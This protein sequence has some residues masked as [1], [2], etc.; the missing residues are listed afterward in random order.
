M[1]MELVALV[2]LIALSAFFSGSETA[3]TSLDGMRTQKLIDAGRF[4]SQALKLWRDR[5]L[6]VLTCILIGN[7]IVN[8]TASVMSDRL[9]SSLLEGTPYADGS[10]PLAIGVMTFIILTFGEI[11]PKT[12][13]KARPDRI[14]GQLMWTL[15]LPYVLFMPLTFFFTH[16]TRLM[17]R[18]MGDDPDKVRP[19]VTEEDIGYMVR[20][21]SEDGN[22]GET[23]QDML[24]SVLELSLTRVKEIMIPRIDIVAID[25]DMSLPEVLE[26]LRSSGH[27]RLPVYEESI[28]NIVGLFYAKDVLEHLVANH[29]SEDGAFNVQD[30]L[31]PPYFVPESKNVS[32]M[33]SEFQKDRIHMAIVVGEFGGTSGLITLEDIIEEVFGD[34]QDEYDSEE[35][36][37]RE[38]GEGHLLVAGR[39]PLEVL[40][41]RLKVTF[42]EHPD[43]DSLGGFVLAETGRLPE[44]GTEI[45]YNDLVMRVTQADA[46][47]VIEVE[48]TRLSSPLKKSIEEDPPLL[49]RLAG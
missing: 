24:E 22:I 37:Y 10:A 27:S 38:L 2:F 42:P 8:I 20:M 4:Y 43:Y 39:C 30:Y 49:R 7:N 41:E 40:E 17:M 21:G 23:K 5:P 25:K 47:R 14:S 31:R 16:M 18:L 9:T 28:D 29:G 1:V 26:R 11:V 44:V 46:K 3:L 34:I 36:Y 12:I 19:L 6:A 45:V 13:A 48:V 32:D 35:D 33:L 15:R